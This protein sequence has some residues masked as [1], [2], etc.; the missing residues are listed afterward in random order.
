MDRATGASQSSGTSHL[1]R[2]FRWPDL[3]ATSRAATRNLR[4]SAEAGDLLLD[5]H[6]ALD[7]DLACV[8]R[9]DS[10]DQDDLDLLVGHRVV[11][12]ASRDDVELPRGEHDLLGVGELDAE[13]A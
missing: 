6:S 10:L 1:T 5:R 9:G 7:D 13:S 12:H 8:P 2:G 4:Q 11:L 3:A